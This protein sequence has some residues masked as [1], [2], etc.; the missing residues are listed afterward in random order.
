V[1]KQLC[2]NRLLLQRSL[3]EH[4][5]LRGPVRWCLL[6]LRQCWLKGQRCWW[7]ESP[8][9]VPQSPPRPSV[10]GRCLGGC[11]EARSRG[12]FRP[13]AKA[14]IR[15]TSPVRTRGSAGQTLGTK[16]ARHGLSWHGGL[17][18]QLGVAQSRALET[19]SAQA[20]FSHDAAAAGWQRQKQQR[21]QQ[22]HS[23]LQPPR[24]QCRR[25]SSARTE[26][27]EACGCSPPVPRA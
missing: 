1:R 26:V 6:R 14:A 12:P 7:S 3:L 5:T 22:A 8:L 15:W 10:R 2:L 23:D 27:L 17:W 19:A 13:Q 21:S 18:G 25:R 4:W 16:E 9:P 20:P 11:R 24:Q